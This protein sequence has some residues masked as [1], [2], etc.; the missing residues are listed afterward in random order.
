MQHPEHVKYQPNTRGKENRQRLALNQG[1]WKEKNRQRL[2][3]NQPVCKSSSR[4][5]NLSHQGTNQCSMEREKREHLVEEK[6]KTLPT[7]TTKEMQSTASA[8]KAKLPSKPKGTR[9]G[10]YN[11]CRLN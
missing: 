1:Q 9:Y 4:K 6:A 3:L 7:L 11:E 8:S 2:A 5:E 10:N